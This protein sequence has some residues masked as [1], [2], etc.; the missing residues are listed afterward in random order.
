MIMKNLLFFILIVLSVYVMVGNLLSE[1]LT[2]APA[3]DPKIKGTVISASWGPPETLNTWYRF[4]VPLTHETFGVDEATF[5]DVISSVTKLRIRTEMYS[6]MDHGSIDEV[7]VGTTFTSDFNSGQEGWSAEGDGTLGW[8]PSDGSDMGGCIQISDWATGDWHYAV[9]PPSWSGDWTSLIGSNI[10]F[11]Y[12][13]DHVGSSYNGSIEISNET[14]KRIVLSTDNYSVPA[15]TSSLVNVTVTP[16]PESNLTINLSASATNCITAPADVII[17]AGETESSFYVTAPNTASAGCES[18]IEARASGYTSSRLTLMVGESPAGATGINVTV[19]NIDATNFPVIKCFATV[20]DAE[21]LM[22]IPNL[23]EKHFTVHEDDIA[24]SPIEVEVISSSTGGRADIVFVFD[25]TG[26]M[27][28]EINGL[29]DRAISFAD[30]L[31]SKGINYRLALVTFDDA[32]DQTHD[33]TSNINEFKGWID[34]LYPSG[35]GDYKENALAGLEEATTLSFRPVSQRMAILITDAEYHQAGESGGGSTPH[36]TTSMIDLLNSYSI[37]THV[38]GP[39]LDPFHELA[40]QTGGLFFNISGDF[41]SIVDRIGNILANQYII[42]YTTHNAVRDNRWRDVELNVTYESKGGMDIGR[43]LVEESITDLTGFDVTI[44]SIDAEGFPVIKAFVSVVDQDSRRS[45]NGLDAS[46]FRVKEDAV[47]ESP[48]YVDV[49]KSGSGARTDIVFVFDVTGSMGGEISGLKERS[50]RFADS[51]AARGIDYRLGLVTYS[52]VVESVHDFTA[53]VNEFKA[54]IDGLRASGGGDTKENAL[55]GLERANLLSYRATSQRMAILITDADFHKAG[56]SGGGTTDQTTD[57]IVN[58]LNSNRIITSCVGP[59]I[60]SF[61]QIADGTGGYWFD[62]DGDFAA[63]I[64]ALGSIITSQYVVTYTTHNP[65]PSNVWRNVEIGVEQ[66]G[67]GGFDTG[68]Y[69][70]GSTMLHT[71]PDHVMGILGNEFSIQVTV[72]SVINLGLVHFNVDYDPAKIR[73]RSIKQGN[74][75][76]Q[77]GATITFVTESDTLGGNI[78]VSTTRAGTTEGANGSGVLAELVFRVIDSNCTST[79]DLNGVDLREPNNETIAVTKKGTD[80]SAA[81]TSGLLGDFDK[82]LD[83]DTKDF[84]LLSTF[85]KP[86]NTTDGDIGPATGTPP[87]LTP[88][89]DGVVNF[90]DLFVFTRM[91]NWFHETVKDRGTDSGLKKSLATLQWKF[92]TDE[93]KRIHCQLYA[94]G[95]SD[96]GMGHLVLQID[97]R[98]FEIDKISNG[99][100][101]QHTGG[102]AVFFADT[103]Q[104][105]GLIDVAF[106]HLGEMA[107]QIEGTGT[108]L[109]MILIPRSAGDQSVQLYTPD[110]RRN[111]NSSFDISYQKETKIESVSPSAYN[112]LPNYPNPFNAHTGI[113]FQVPE[114]SQVHIQILNILGQPVKLLTNKTW[115]AGEH[116]LSWDGT[117]QQGRTVGSGIYILR[118]QAGP[119]SKTR[120]ILLLK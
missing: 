33:F 69:L 68:R 111:D 95:F 71:S 39:D 38:V 48:V 43:Y 20:V 87:N 51:L 41:A 45:V 62:I 27:G 4:S 116:Q 18:V 94:D 101:Y 102:Q 109:D 93:Q 74:F 22:P 57:S 60:D 14:Q 15:A 103:D 55:E 1:T 26:S 59:D 99:S 2:Q 5:L 44:S 114:K 104:E 110:M 11:Y 3:D 70:V 82:D 100:L 21:S 54:W 23:S 117:D 85:W 64:D 108:L 34:A 75:L 32:V 105:S 42:T 88:V 36:T 81:I 8:L 19:Q 58:L 112:L 10:V 72:E 120:E 50:I 29:K 46:N 12:K 91:W 35:G 119:Y 97:P 90:E 56:E 89:P 24:E 53:D 79:L 52:D 98:A 76:A 7:S 77:N 113:Q 92:S 118:M 37:S 96:L 61:H 31:A 107:N 80:I 66:S 6:G 9:A 28:G 40:D 67:K 73:F 63:I 83:I 16:A 65:V 49:I 84:A 30:S 13:T 47:S 17:P 86:A 115:Q 78:E 25:T 106:A